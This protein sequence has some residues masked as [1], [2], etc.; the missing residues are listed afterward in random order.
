MTRKTKLILLI[1]LALIGVLTGY[2]LMERQLTI[3]VNGEAREINTRALNVRGALRSAGIKL[4][5]LDEVSPAASSWLSR[6][7][8]I[9]VNLARRVQVFNESDRSL[10]EVV[11]AASTPADMLEAAG[12]TASAQDLV[13]LN[14]LPVE[15]NEPVL[16]SGQVSLQYRPAVTLSV[17]L[18]GNS[19][20]FATSAATL[21]QALWQQGIKLHGGDDLDQPL[22]ANPAE[23]TQVTIHSAVPLIITADGRDLNTFIAAPSIGEALAKAGIS[24]QDLDYSKPTEN[25]PLPAD[26]R[27]FVVRVREE[28]LSEQQTIAYETQS[29]VDPTLAAG[30]TQVVTTGENG[31]Q[32]ARVA[33]RYEDGLEVSRETLSTVVIK[34]AVNAVIKTGS[35]AVAQTTTNADCAAYTYYLA[36]P[37]TLTSYSPCNLGTDYCGYITASGAELRKGL[38]GVHRDWYNVLKGTEICI[39]GYGVGTVADIG[40]YQN[41]HNW[42]DLGYTDAEYDAAPQK[43][44]FNFTVYFLSPKVAELGLTP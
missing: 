10:V 19:Q 20:T 24:L 35:K 18:D 43:T 11:T 1:C 28:I 8:Y 3:S 16:T 22:D 15:L 14:G 42:I 30:Q 34:A 23:L 27:I 32:L 5:A 40:V 13:R 44:F 4:T 39:P 37:V 31:L 33:V 12:I 17:T 38:L 36:L 2:I 7:T 26:G 21:G 6:T 25:E 9:E 41:N 29:T